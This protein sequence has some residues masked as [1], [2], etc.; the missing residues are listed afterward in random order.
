MEVDRDL[1]RWVFVEQAGDDFAEL[2]LTRR[3]RQV[4]DRAIVIMRDPEGVEEIAE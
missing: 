1:F 2:F 4:F 3:L